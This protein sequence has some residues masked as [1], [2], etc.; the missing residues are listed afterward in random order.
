[1]NDQ[2]TRKNPLLDPGA[3]PRFEEIEP[4]HV[5]PAV[6]SLLTDLSAALDTLEKSASQS[7][8]P[9]WASLIEPIERISDRL[10]RCWGVVGHLMGV[11]NGPELR[12]AQEAVQPEVVKFG[13][14]L[15]QSRYLYDAI[16]RLRDGEAWNT[17]DPTQHRIVEQLL[18]DA[19][20]SGVGL[21]GAERDR[22][23][24][25]QL[26]L[27][28]LSTRFSNNVLDA[29]KAFAL[30]LTLEDEVDGLP[31]SARALAAQA[32]R[33]AG[34]ASATPEKG[35]WRITLDA[36]AL[37]PFLE[38]ARR[39][40]L[41][42]KLY[43]AYLTRASEGETDNTGRI[44][45]ILALK[46]EQAALLGFGSAAEASLATKMAPGV[47]AVEA[48]LGELRTASYDAASRD[49]AELSAFAAGAGEQA[50]LLHWDISFWSERMREEL[51]ELSEEELRPYFPLPTVLDGLFA[52]A[53]RLFGV[54]IE[55]AD[56]EVQVW[57]PDVRYF[58]V[59]DETGTPVAAFYLDPYSRPSEKR[60]GA[61]MDEC[62]GRARTEDGEP[63][64]PVAYVVCNQ[65]APVENRPALMTFSEL[66]TIFHEFGHALQHMLTRVDH[67]LASGIRG[68][69][70]DAVE[71]PSQFME[72]WCYHK[73]TLVGLSSH[74]DTGEPLPEAL[75]DRITAA[76]N[77]RSGT[78]ML[79]QIY[80]A[81]L[82]MELHHRWRPDGG[83]DPFGVQRRIAETNAV[84]QPLPEDRFLCSFGHIF[85]GG[86]SAGYYS[87]K[88]AEVLSADAFAAFEEAGLDDPAALRETGRR[89]RDTVL[90][91]GGSRAPMEVFK[92]FR[93]REPSTEALLRHSGLAT[94]P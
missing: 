16:T 2:A 13:T 37:G 8:E 4:A 66:R 80:F 21:D 20:L 49:L 78:T 34:S 11:K 5:E 23:N 83:D 9:T 7:P 85:A 28:E 25:I 14:R 44:E 43:R 67:P 79:R 72:N 55:A 51:Y 12:A 54:R 71:L 38:H 68:V 3:A 41:R 93:G 27:A 70:W 81:T 33:E 10:E 52:L 73:D 57:H 89:F 1:M 19:R 45:R 22:F 18:L 26:E 46:H 30:D 6:T 31:S 47:A 29:T 90:A 36:P 24:A 58:R 50:E 84:M 69:E 87:Y 32:A 91:L 77:F 75:F 60:G 53:L 40:D 86:Y 48:L 65:T 92:T 82:D 39:R 61:W 62:V 76:R 59:L 35:P 15:A 42:E 74:V 17:L 94:A 56:G 64:L 63:R 88:W